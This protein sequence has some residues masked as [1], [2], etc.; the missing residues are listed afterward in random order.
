MA[1]GRHRAQA[2]LGLEEGVVL[3]QPLSQQV[4]QLLDRVNTWTALN[5]FDDLTITGTCTG[6]GGAGGGTV[7]SVAIPKVPSLPVNSAPGQ[8]VIASRH[9]QVERCLRFFR[10]RSL[11]HVPPNDPR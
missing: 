9:A 5:T 3:A 7:T 10:G 11:P 1:P 8:R 6:C 4:L 2:V